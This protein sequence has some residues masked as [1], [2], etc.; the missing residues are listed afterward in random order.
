MSAPTAV[1]RKACW[2]ARDQFWKCLDENQ[3][4]FSK[5]QKLRSSFEACCPQLWV[6]HFDKRRD[7]LKYKEKLEAGEFQPSETT[8]KL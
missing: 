4:D 6:K 3:D 2:G 5:C 1:E 7:Y 8:G